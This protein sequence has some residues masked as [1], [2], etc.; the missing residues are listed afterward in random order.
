MIRASP[1]NQVYQ[2]GSSFLA[3]WQAF[4][5]AKHGPYGRPDFGYNYDTLKGYLTPQFGGH[6]AGGGGGNHE[7]KLCLRLIAEF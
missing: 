3:D 2:P 7:L 5:A 1:P 4:L 6:R